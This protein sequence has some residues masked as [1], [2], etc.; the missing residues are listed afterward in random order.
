ME[1][2]IKKIEELKEYENNPRLNDKAV[3][4]VANSISDFGFKVPIVIDKDNIIVTG[5]TRFKAAMQLGLK[6]VPCII[7]DDLNNEQIKAFRLIDNKVSEFALWNE[8]K[9][10]KEIESGIAKLE[11]YGFN[12]YELEYYENKI[13]YDE[14]FEEEQEPKEKEPTYCTCPYCGEVFEE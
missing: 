10:Q 1:V 3:E 4:F 12:E 9:L 14:F 2:I 8:D 7:A 5:H 13:D 11:R 6:E